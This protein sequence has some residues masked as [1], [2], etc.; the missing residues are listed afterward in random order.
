MSEKPSVHSFSQSI[1]VMSEKDW[2]DIIHIIR[3]AP[4]SNMDSAEAVGRLL[5]R[6]QNH[7][8][9]QLTDD[10]LKPGGTA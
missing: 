4:L 5:L 8:S 6:L 10:D 9:E 3:A 2:A 7:I 1:P